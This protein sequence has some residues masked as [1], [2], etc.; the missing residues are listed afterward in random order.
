MS[1]DPYD[2]RATRTRAYHPGL[3][4][5][6]P[7][8]PSV[9]ILAGRM[10]RGCECAEDDDLW[11]LSSIFQGIGGSLGVRPS[12]EMR[13][14]TILRAAGFTLQQR[15]SRAKS[16]TQSSCFYGWLCSFRV[17]GYDDLANVKAGGAKPLG[18]ATRADLTKLQNIARMPRETEAPMI[19]EYSHT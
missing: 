8:Q 1:P 16:K 12:K 3:K 6:D 5:G 19:F 2:E 4:K 10:K 17:C 9:S 11:P 14:W 15:T 18:P 13:K 7:F